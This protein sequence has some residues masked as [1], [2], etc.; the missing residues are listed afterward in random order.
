[1]AGHRTY[2]WIGLR[3]TT[4][5]QET[6]T[7]D[8]M[9]QSL[10]VGWL[11]LTLVLLSACEQRPEAARKELGQLGIPYTPDAFITSVANH[12]VVAVNLFLVPGWIPIRHPRKGF[13]HS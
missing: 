9:R 13:L 2:S 12:D 5:R 8:T 3:H 4:V 7:G 11:L 6:H 10:C 1:M